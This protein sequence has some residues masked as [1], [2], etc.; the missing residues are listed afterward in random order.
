MSRLSRTLAAVTFV[1][2]LASAQAG[3]K[4]PRDADSQM[5]AAQAAAIRPGD[6]S[7]GCAALQKEF[8]ENVKHPAVLSYIEK[9]GLRTKEDIAK[10]QATRPAAA[11]Q[12]M[13]TTITTRVSQQLR[14]QPNNDLMG[15]MPQLMRGQRVLELAKAGKCEWLQTSGPSTGH[16]A[17]H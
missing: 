7:L 11:A 6:E 9:S 17:G 14:K 5:A 4:N 15:I 3:S 12:V 16:E 10:V 1:S 13:L 8:L 2:V